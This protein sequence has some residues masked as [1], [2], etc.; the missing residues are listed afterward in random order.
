MNASEDQM[1]SRLGSFRRD[2]LPHVPRLIVDGDVDDRLVEDFTEAIFK[3][4]VD[5]HGPAVLD[6]T[7]VTYFGSN[8]IGALITAEALAH[9]HGVELTIEPSRIV[10]RVFEITGLAEFFGMVREYA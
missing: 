9:D 7:R 8:G 3:T 6:L 1:D 10:R 5:A 2:D 4:I